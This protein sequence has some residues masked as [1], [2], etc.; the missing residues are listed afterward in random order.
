MAWDRFE[1]G[2]AI[3]KMVLEEG[4]DEDARAVRDHLID[5]A[6][7]WAVHFPN[8]AFRPM[9]R[10]LVVAADADDWDTASEI[11]WAMDRRIPDGK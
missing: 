2:L 9:F 4:S 10:Q 3:T 1:H 11:A 5:W 6:R 7:Y 8:P